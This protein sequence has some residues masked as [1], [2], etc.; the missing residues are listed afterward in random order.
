MDE[1]QQVVKTPLPPFDT[2]AYLQFS[3]TGDRQ[4]MEKNAN[5]RNRQTDTVGA[6]ECVEY[7][8]SYLPHLAEVMDGLAAAPSWTLSAHDPQLLNLH[9]TRFYVDLGAADLADNL[10][11][12]LYL[13]GDKL[14]AATRTHV[15]GEMERHVFTPMRSSFAAGGK[16][17]DHNGNWWLYADMNWNAVCLK[18]I[19]GA[20]LAVLP[21]V[22]D[23][24]LFVAAA[25]DFIRHYENGFNP[26]G[27]DTEG[28]TYWNYGFS[29]F[30]ELRENLMR[31]TSGKIDLLQDAKM[32]KVAFF[33]MNFPMLPNNARRVW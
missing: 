2:E 17:S 19:T 32:R 23:R 8:G 7:K 26:D 9:G 20:A 12:A 5:E 1:A 6:A 27:Y 24:G 10:A 4:P 15:L 25:E 22:E 21:G 31:A 18:G 28:L 30:I 3:K 29:H 33:G 11:E 16:P 13:L 14:P